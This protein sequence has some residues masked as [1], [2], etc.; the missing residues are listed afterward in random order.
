MDRQLGLNRIPTLQLDPSC[1]KGEVSDASDRCETCGF[2]Y[3]LGTPTLVGPQIVLTAALIS[4]LVDTEIPTV[5]RRPDPDTWS[6]LEYGCHVR[7]VLLVQRER[8]LLALRVDEPTV[9]AMGRDERVAADGYSDQRPADVA[10]QIGDAALMFTGVLARLDDQSWQ[11][12]MI[13]GYPQR[14]SRSVAWVAVHSLHELV[15][16]LGDVQRQLQPSAP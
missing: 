8:V 7:D 4:G 11:R 9:V 14:A 5:A 16:H 1:Y 2:V 15:H 3:D 13:Y 10:R 12:T 6:I